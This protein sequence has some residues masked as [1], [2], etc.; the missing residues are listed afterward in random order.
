MPQGYAVIDKEGNYIVEPAYAKIKKDTDGYVVKNNDGYSYL[1]N[2]G[3]SKWQQTYEQATPFNEKHALV[4]SDGKYRIINQK[5]QIIRSLSYDYVT[6]AG[7]GYWKYL[8]NDQ[9]GILDAVGKVIKEPTFVD[10]YQ[11]EEGFLVAAIG[12]DQWGIVNENFEITIP[13][14]YPLLWSYKNGYARIISEGFIQVINQQGQILPNIQEV[15][16][17]DFYNGLARF[18]KYPSFQK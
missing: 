17:R 10:C 15:E 3:E 11:F 8:Q 2:H 18:Q 7:Q 9:W 14:K 1:D 12:K 13:F 6:S 5:G 16:L 4:K